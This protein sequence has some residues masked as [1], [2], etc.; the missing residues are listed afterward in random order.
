MG[1]SFLLQL[2]TVNKNIEVAETIQKLSDVVEAVPTIGAYDG[3][4]KTENLTRKD[5]NKLV[6]TNICPLDYVRS[7]LTMHEVPKVPVSKNV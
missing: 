4:V 3:I 7:V 1:T 2:C 5:V 6:L